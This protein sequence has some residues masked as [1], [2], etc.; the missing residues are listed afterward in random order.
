MFLL[1]FSYSAF[2]QNVE[3]LSAEGRRHFKSAMLYK[4]EA[5][6]ISDYCMVISELL[7]VC[8]TD[9][10]ADVYIELGRC[11]SLYPTADAEKKQRSVS[12]RLFG[13]LQTDVMRY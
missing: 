2:A 11:Y 13:L 8:E 6:C 5:K 12:M 1:L 10:S 7:K 3:N 4:D 9:E